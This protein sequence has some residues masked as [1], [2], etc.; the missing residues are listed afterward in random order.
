MTLRNS[1][2]IFLDKETFLSFFFV[3]LLLFFFLRGIHFRK[4]VKFARREYKEVLRLSISGHLIKKKKLPLFDKFL[5]TI[6]NNVI[7][8]RNAFYSMFGSNHKKMFRKLI[9]RHPYLSPFLK[10]ISITVVSL[11]IF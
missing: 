9:E 2:R 11:R 3:F 7:I 5:M 10:M 6:L 8:Q 4:Y 1:E